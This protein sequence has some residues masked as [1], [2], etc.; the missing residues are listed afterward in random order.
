MGERFKRLRE[1]AGLSQAEAAAVAGVPFT[2]LRNW[3]QDR[4]EPLLGAAA[5][6][7]V[8]LGCTLDEL[9]GIAEPAAK[10]GKGK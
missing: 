7:A 9:A 8:A 2:T 1:R 3:E 6:L 5:K 10:K 4:R